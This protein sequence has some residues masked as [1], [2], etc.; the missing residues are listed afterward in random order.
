MLAGL[1]IAVTLMGVAL[2]LTLAWQYGYFEPPAQI[3]AATLLSLGLS[4]GGLY[5]HTK[6]AANIG[7]PALLATG[8]A[9][10][11]LTVFIATGYYHFLPAFAGLLIAGA[12][13]VDGLWLGRVWRQQ[14]VAV[15]TLIGVIVLATV[16]GAQPLMTAAFLL[17]I[18]ATSSLI[19]LDLAWPV[20]RVVEVI[21]TALALC[22]LLLDAPPA[23]ALVIAIL[24]ALV[25]AAVAIW[26]VRSPASMHK[27]SVVLMI[28]AALPLV[29]VCLAQQSPWDTVGLL[30]TGLAY[31]G[32]VAWQEPRAAA[33]SRTGLAFGASMFALASASYFE[34]E[35]LLIVIAALAI[36]YLAASTV[37]GKFSL[38]V[39]VALQA[40][41][42]AIWISFL[43]RR[44]DL[45]TQPSAYPGIGALIGTLLLIACAWVLISALLANWPAPRTVVVR[46]VLVGASI[47]L[48]SVA[49]LQA[50][51]ILG[52]AMGA[53]LQGLQIGHIT[54]TISWVALSAVALARA[55]RV[56][57]PMASV[58]TGLALA[59]ASVAKLF[60]Y[61]LA[62]Q[63][64]LVRSLGFLVVGISLLLIGTQ[65]AKAL[66][67]AK[68]HR[69]VQGP[70]T[71]PP[72]R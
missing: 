10:A 5:I 46:R 55:L 4:G 22:L 66:S 30:G 57:N 45:T 41:G 6:D 50:S 7:A 17:V 54:V 71:M 18:T 21:P 19:S 3:I 51:V 64:A 2:L 61:D 47:M 37:L 15:P 25:N 44:W 14:W 34:G 35:T 52:R 39:G 62:E 12:I 13:A 27:L 38:Y 65:Y 20:L 42:M 11:Y 36:S 8:I 67:T 23:A 72:T 28:V 49:I 70:P 63:P 9:S 48:S 68:S 33:L 31:T 60:L 59:I 43:S 56:P 24:F 69:P 26:S 1:G 16:L 40:I 32:L 53:G 29:F 58:Y